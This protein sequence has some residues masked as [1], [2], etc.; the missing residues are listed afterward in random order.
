MSI[1]FFFCAEYD[2]CFKDNDHLDSQSYFLTNFAI[3]LCMGW[4]Q[5]LIP[6]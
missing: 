4:L 2:T 1:F 6:F 5:V 3:I